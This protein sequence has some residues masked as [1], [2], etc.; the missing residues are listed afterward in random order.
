MKRIVIFAG[1]CTSVVAV[2]CAMERTPVQNLQCKI[3]NLGPAFEQ[4][5]AQAVGKPFEEQVRLWDEVIEKPEADFYDSVVWEKDNNKTWQER[6]PRRLNYMF[7][8]YPVIYQKMKEG[9]ATFNA[10]AEAQLAKFRQFF[11]NSCRNLIL[12]VVPSPTFNGKESMLGKDVVLAFGIDMMTILG[13]NNDVLFAHELFHYYHAE[14][15]NMEEN[16]KKNGLMWHLWIDGLAQYVSQQMN[17]GVN[18]A[19]ILFDQRL[20]DISAQ[21]MVWLAQKFLADVESSSD[22]D[23][24]WFCAGNDGKLR[25]DLPSRCGYLLGLYAVEQLAKKYS[26][27]S[28]V[29]WTE[30]EVHPKVIEILLTLGS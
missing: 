25:A 21:D 10:V 30:E 24:I 8:Q 18:K 26:L 11:P 17:P 2:I 13:G 27:E 22:K 12:Y 6:K 1:I 15:V 3:V 20:G 16:G 19:A 23:S 5:W 9:F 14:Q 4:F 28:M 29:K 7:S